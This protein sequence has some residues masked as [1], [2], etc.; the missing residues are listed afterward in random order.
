MEKEK[1]KPNQIG[2]IDDLG[3]MNYGMMKVEDFIKII[4]RQIDNKENV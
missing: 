2:E 1:R 3:Y 4:K